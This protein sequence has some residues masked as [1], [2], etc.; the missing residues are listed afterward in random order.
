MKK[1]IFLLLAVLLINTVF[2]GCDHN[3]S[4]A[5]HISL[6]PDIINMKVGETIKVTAKMTDGKGKSVSVDN[7]KFEWSIVTGEDAISI[8]SNG[9]IV[10]ITAKK[11]VSGNAIIRLTHPDAEYRVERVVHITE[12]ESG[13]TGNTSIKHISLEPDIINIKVGETIE[14]TAKITDGNDQTVTVD[15]SKFEWSIAYGNEAIEIEPN[16]NTIKITA[17]KTIIGNAMIKISHPDALNHIQRVVHITKEEN[18]GGDTGNTEPSS[19]HISLN[20]DII[21]VKVGKTI[22]VTARIKDENGQTLTVDNS[23]FEWSI[24]VDRNLIEIKPNGN[25]AKITAKNV[26]YNGMEMIEIRHPDAESTLEFVKIL[27]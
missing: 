13:N 2:V 25:K 26:G 23:K 17:K 18:S 5:K 9:N 24:V 20:P 21:N 3:T 15:N 12:E 14:V 27:E 7:S 8:V 16:G 10:E 22:E 4:K 6:N 1:V 19:K 11:V